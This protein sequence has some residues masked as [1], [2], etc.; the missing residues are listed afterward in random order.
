MSYD[1]LKMGYSMGTISLAISL[2][3][4]DEMLSW[5]AAL[6]GF[7]PRSSFW[8]PS[9]VMLM[10]EAILYLPDIVHLVLNSVSVRSSLLENA[11]WNCAFSILAFSAGSSCNRPFW[12]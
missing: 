12:S 6:C 5:P 10:L 1:L 11:F 2:K 3:I 8:M 7:R 9:S 4:R